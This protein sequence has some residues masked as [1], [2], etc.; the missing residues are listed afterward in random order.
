MPEVEGMQLD[1]G[2][3]E[4]IREQISRI[5]IQLFSDERLSTIVIDLLED[6]S[7][8]PLA[9]LVDSSNNSLITSFSRP[10]PLFKESQVREF[11]LLHSTLQK[12][13]ESLDMN[14]KYSYFV[15]ESDDYAVVACNGGRL[16]SVASGAMKTPIEN[17]YDAA[18]S[19]C[20]ADV[21]D[22]EIERLTEGIL[23]GEMV[24]QEGRVLSSSG[25]AVPTKAQIFISTLEK[26]IESLFRSL[27]RRP[28]LKFSVR[29]VGDS[30]IELVLN[31]TNG[32]LKLQLFQV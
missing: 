3:K 20:Y 24:F 30:S 6:R 7:D 14:P 25:S 13:L 9:F 26:N 21:F 4:A 29:I 5:N 15:V 1:P 19:I 31:R 32:E 28:F 16:L 17:V 22:P 8:I 10:R 27:T 12:T 2:K 23:V 11:L 18:T